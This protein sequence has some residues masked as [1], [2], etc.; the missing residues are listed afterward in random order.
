MGNPKY[1][2]G[3][4][5]T[6]HPDA[7]A[8]PLSWKSPRKIFVN[9]MSDLFHE[10]MSE[11]FLRKCF[12]VMEQADWHVYQILTKRPERMLSFVRRYGHVPDHIWLGTSVEMGM[13][14]S[15]IDVL[16]HV[17]CQI[18]FISFEPLIGPIG[19]VDL[20]GVSWAIVG[21]ESGPGHRPI[22]EEWIREIRDQCREQGVSFFFKQW[23]GV[24]PK[25]GGRSFDGREWNEYPS[26]DDV[27]KEPPL[28]P[29]FPRISIGH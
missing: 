16:K 7:L 5:F 19:I 9:S 2:N 15:R 13:Y 11:R 24:T 20:A 17:D 25:S 18:K 10:N 28:A 1:K 14:K 26:M 3:F 22:L 27:S 4:R 29:P 23:G 6:V 12:S 8:L 21:G